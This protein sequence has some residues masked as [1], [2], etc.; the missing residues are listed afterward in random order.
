MKVV[1]KFLQWELW[2]IVLH[3]EVGEKGEKEEA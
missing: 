3:W 2:K 1:I